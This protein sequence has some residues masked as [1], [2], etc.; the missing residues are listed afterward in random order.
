MKP[1]KPLPCWEEYLGI[2]QSTVGRI[3]LSA[4]SKA[5]TTLL[6]VFVVVGSPTTIAQQQAPAQAARPQDVAPHVPSQSQQGP[7]GERAEHFVSAPG[8]SPSAIVPLTGSA[9]MVSDGSMV[10]IVGP[11]ESKTMI[12]ESRCLDP[13]Q[14]LTFVKQAIY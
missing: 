10:A 2:T 13:L 1:D 6:G 14:R 12:S 9:V 11:H 3:I 5:V 7:P 4:Y 8:S